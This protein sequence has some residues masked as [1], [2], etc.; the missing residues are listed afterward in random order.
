[1]YKNPKTY[2][3]MPIRFKFAV[4]SALYWDVLWEVL[5]D[6]LVVYIEYLSACIQ[7]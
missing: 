4:N 2:Q 6:V 7:D 5:W 3:Y 1:M